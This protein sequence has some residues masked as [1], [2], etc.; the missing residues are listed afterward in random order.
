MCFCLQKTR[1]PFW[2]RPAWVLSIGCE[3][4][5]TRAV[6]VISLRQDPLCQ[7]KT[8]VRSGGCGN[9]I[10]IKLSSFMPLFGSASFEH[11][12]TPKA[13]SFLQFS[14]WQI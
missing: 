13:H 2:C 7:H 14:T 1:A 3:S 8:Y 4:R 6:V 10:I 12:K 9:P 11:A 5:V